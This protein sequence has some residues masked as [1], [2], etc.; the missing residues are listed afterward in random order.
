MKHKC[1]FALL[2]A[3]IALG[4]LVGAVR[5][6]EAPSRWTVEKLAGAD[7]LAERMAKYFEP[8]KIEAEAKLKPYAL[9]LDLSKL[10]NADFGKLVWP[11]RQ[12]E[13]AEAAQAM[14]RKNAFVVLPGGRRDDVAKFYQ[15]IKQRGLPV[16]VT[17]DSL[18]HLYHVQFDETL[19]DIEE[20]EFFDEALRI[21]R[22]VQA[23]ALK[24]HGIAK[25]DVKKAARLLVGFATVPVVLLNQADL[26]QE[27]A[28][29]LK[30]V[31]GWKQRPDWRTM[32]AFEQT[33]GE[34]LEV[35]RKQ[36][37]DRAPRRGDF[38]A[39]LVTMLKAYLAK[40]PA[41]R[42]V[43]ELIPDVVAE[44][45]RAEL[46]RIAA[47]Q[48]FAPSPLFAYKEDYS[49]YQ[50]RGHYTRSKKLKQY[51]KALMWYGRMTFIIRGEDRDAGIRG[52][53]P[54][55]TARVQTLAASLLAGMMDRP[56]QGDRT[57]AQA[58]DRLYSVTAYYVGFADD[59]TPYEYR[60]ALRE[61]V[62]KEFGPGA[63]TDAKKFFE[64]RKKLAQMRPPEIYSGLGDIVGPP[65]GIATEKDL[66]EAL[67]MTQGLRLMGQRYV[68][69]SYMMG[70]LVY[71]TVGPY[72]GGAEKPFTFVMSDGGPIRG[73]PRGLDVLAV[74]GC[75]RARHWLK[76]LGDDQ[77][78][79]YDETLAKLRE[80]FSG[81]SEAD[82]NR[83]MYW[84]WLHALKG[85]LGEYGQGYPSFMRT[86]AWRDKQLSAALASWAQLRH[87]TILYAKQSYTMRAGSA[88]MRPKMV[89]GYVEPAV[90]FY[91][92]LLALTRM[93]RKGLDDMKVLDRRAG[94]RLEALEGVVQRLADI[95]VKE[96]A[97]EK[98]TQD[99]Y[100]FIR[101]FGDRLKHVVAGVN[102]EGL[103]TTIVA[104]VH[105]DANTGLVLEEGTGYLHMMVVVYPMPD[106]G[107]VAG[108]GPALSHYEFKHPMSDRLT[109]EAWKQ[110]LRG[111]KQPD[112]PPWTRT[113]TAGME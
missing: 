58:W 70:K 62:G 79:R 12:Q 31:Q 88:P 19:K 22:A 9:P 63:L 110:M 44:D 66:A 28:A 25:G 11:G 16:F 33:Y 56:L 35:L 99:D 104:D 57:I 75:D 3:G 91:G 38:K 40:H 76:E 109:D 34:L 36:R 4:G 71:P 51:F 14:L 107:L 48:G 103:E 90:E 39:G 80:Q 55:E 45:V 69:D 67:A 29:A 97:G 43:S 72:T 24:I 102:E 41:D 112:L 111:P 53:V 54:M 93:T 78:Q 17:T 52:V 59:L 101:S 77:Y 47:H 13:R 108:V 65:A 100:A 83:N 7:G 106:G 85:L 42:D 18:L 96:L 26:G 92:R 98:L 46:E 68:P 105:T 6:D 49:Q 50:P 74:L 23:E 32:Q 94:R 89:E 113:F 8:V 73:F 20:R 87:D 61:A 60:A 27:A 2:V 81:L 1:L 64:L 30:E 5:A 37:R 21:S 10:T 15:S 82:W 84:S 95:S 86:E